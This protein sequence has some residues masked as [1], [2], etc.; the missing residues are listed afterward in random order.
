MKSPKKVQFKSIAALYP[1]NASKAQELIDMESWLKT[2]RDGGITVRANGSHEEYG[3]LVHHQIVESST[4]SE[5]LFV[6]ARGVA[7]DALSPRYKKWNA[8]LWKASKP[9]ISRKQ[10]RAHL[11]S[12][13]DNDNRDLNG[14]L[15]LLNEED[16]FCGVISTLPKTVGKYFDV[17]SDLADL[18]RLWTDNFQQLFDKKLSDRVFDYI[19]GDR[20]EWMVT[21]D[22]DA[23]S[24][25]SGL[26]SGVEV[27]LSGALNFKNVEE[28]MENILEMTLKPV[29]K[30]YQERLVY[31][32]SPDTCYFVIGRPMFYPVL[33]GR[34]TDGSVEVSIFDAMNER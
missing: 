11:A 13:F 22:E 24:E 30:G 1:L 3:T 19:E 28:S 32:A 10:Y 7:R 29:F 18:D 6:L 5:N 25:F 2:L 16:P 34:R 4:A 8:N 31:I 15:A 33:V 23:S 20:N 9:E 12:E 27:A 17:A 21:R 26:L 14:V